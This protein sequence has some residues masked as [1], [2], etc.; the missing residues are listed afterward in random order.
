MEKE[1]KVDVL[2]GILAGSL[3]VPANSQKPTIVLIISGS[4]P[5]DRNGNNALSG[6]TN[7]LKQL[8]HELAN[9]NVASLRFDKRGVGGSQ[10]A[11]IPEE[12]LKLQTFV[13][14]V[15]SWLTYIH[16]SSKFG[17][18][19][20]LGHSEGGL[21]AIK[22]CQ[23]IKVAGCILL[24]TPGQRLAEVLQHQLSQQLASQPSWLQ[25]SL[26]ILAS[27]QNGNLVPQVPTELQSI[28]RPSVQ[29]YLQS[30]LN[31]DPAAE[32]AKIDS[33]ILIVQGT[34][35]LQVT[36]SDAKLL[37]QAVPKAKLVII[38]KMN[39]VLKEVPKSDTQSNLASYQQPNIPL[40]TQLVKQITFFLNTENL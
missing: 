21:I 16:E 14:D 7:N 28:F 8:A 12:K 27:L 3:I 38:A 23:R 37:K 11:T 36:I 17:K 25:K 29:P 33:P 13:N 30:I 18:I 19:F 1:V 24:A 5:T 6:K 2:G 40:N 4:G 35:D 9:K 32:L 15:L 34:E 31:V 39:H 20:V 22:A 10:S 26:N